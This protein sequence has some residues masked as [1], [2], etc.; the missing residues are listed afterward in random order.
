M[1]RV[2]E[3]SEGE[4]ARAFA[5]FAVFR[6]LGP[7]RTL[8]SAAGLFYGKEDGPSQGEYDTVKRWSARFDWAERVR[9]YDSWLAMERRDAIQRHMSERADAHARRESE[10]REKA[11]EIRER[12]AEK[13][14]AMLKTPLFKQ[15]R[16]VEDGP[17]GE[18]VR[19]VM[20]PAGWNIGTAVNLFNLSQAH[21]GL[22]AEEVEVS[23]DLSFENLSTDEI[24]TL[25][26]LDGKIV[27]RSPQTQREAE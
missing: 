16:I 12:A 26:E 14:L 5:C 17:D 25:L 1:S 11:L 3:P 20:I 21:A 13:S 9:H 10:L 8:R 22:T 6:D 27:V 18:A 4:S 24:Q 7:E 23:G 15:E 2:W 19:L